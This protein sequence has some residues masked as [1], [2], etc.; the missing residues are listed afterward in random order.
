MHGLSA[1]IL[2][3]LDA[4][5]KEIIG[6]V[7]AFFED[8]E[9]QLAG[10]HATRSADGL[11]HRGHPRVCLPPKGFQLDEW[12]RVL[13]R[14][15][16]QPMETWATGWEQW[17]MDGLERDLPAGNV[18]ANCR[19]CR[20][21]RHPGARPRAVGAWPGGWPAEQSWM[22]VLDESWTRRSPQ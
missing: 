5:A 17:E 4:E 10:Q 12:H 13:L 3:A 8:L 22:R 21:A 14:H 6:Q 2:H 19:C 18:A 11:V 7:E 20:A 15:Q 16:A 9:R 1:E